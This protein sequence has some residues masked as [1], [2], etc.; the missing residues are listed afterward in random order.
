MKD[1]EIAKRNENWGVPPD[2][3]YCVLAFAV[4]V[5]WPVADGVA[6]VWC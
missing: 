5:V 2:W 1:Y 4:F 6:L 3:F